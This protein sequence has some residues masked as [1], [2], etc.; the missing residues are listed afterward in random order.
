LPLFLCPD[1]I[2]GEKK[3]K[4]QGQWLSL[5]QYFGK[6]RGSGSPPPKG[7]CDPVPLHH[8]FKKNILLQYAKKLITLQKLQ[9]VEK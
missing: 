2:K 3:V 8:F 9:K 4:W 1:F 7:G 6:L 5:G